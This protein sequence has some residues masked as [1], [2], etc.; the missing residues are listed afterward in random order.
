MAPRRSALS[1]LQVVRE[2]FGARSGNLAYL[3]SGL[4]IAMPGMLIAWLPTYFSRYHDMD[5]KK[6]GLMAGVAVLIA[7]IGMIVGGGLA[8]RLSVKN[9][10]RRALVPAVYS[11]LT[12]VILMAAFALPPGP[13]GLGLI[14]LG[15]FFAAAQ[16]GC[17]AALTLRRHPPGRARHGD[18][19]PGPGQQP[20]RPGAGPADRRPA[21]GSGGPEDGDDGDTAA[22]VGGRRLLRARLAQLRGRRGAQPGQDAA[23]L[24]RP[25]AHR[26]TFHRKPL[27]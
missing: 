17:S 18:G 22:G 4:Q 19:D 3:A 6:A 26:S 5:M 13:L 27:P 25:L 12:A 14:M 8:D 9:P 2:V 15:A 21:V 24:T 23:S 1:A 7:G 10:R 20:D 11:V 16:G